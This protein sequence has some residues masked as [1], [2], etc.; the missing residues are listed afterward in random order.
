MFK[1][2]L[3]GIGTYWYHNDPVKQGFIA[4]TPGMEPTTSRLML[5][6]ARSTVNSPFISFVRA[7]RDSEILAHG[8]IPA[9]CV[10]N[11]FDVYGDS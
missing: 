1:S 3:T 5:H 8:A 2:G 11:S 7:L 10:R 4:R 9:T 6:I